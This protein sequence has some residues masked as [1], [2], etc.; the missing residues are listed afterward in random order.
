MVCRVLLP[1]LARQNRRAETVPVGFELACHSISMLQSA[2][3][4]QSCEC[5]VPDV[6]NQI[7]Y[8]LFVLSPLHPCNGADVEQSKS[9]LTDT[10]QL[11]AT[12]VTIARQNT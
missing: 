9:M 1:S 2:G 10:A 4:K 3:Q 6:A 12:H 7:A 5:A 8:T 11:L